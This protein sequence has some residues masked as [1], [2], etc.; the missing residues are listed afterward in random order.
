MSR[1]KRRAL[2]M[3]RSPTCPWCRESYTI[4]NPPTWDHIIPVSQGGTKEDGRIIVC[5]YC[6]NGR[7]SAPFE[8]YCQA[9]YVEW[10]AA[11]RERRAYK[12]P[13]QWG[14]A[15]VGFYIGTESRRV[16]R[17]LRNAMR[18]NLAGVTEVAE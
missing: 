15:V 11:Q 5:S 1:A 2:R 12:R 6:N 10:L 3:H 17:E 7:A 8:E 14:D 18:R 13:R 9:V 16:R 4:D